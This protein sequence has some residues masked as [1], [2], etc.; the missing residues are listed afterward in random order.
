[1]QA[2]TG[3]SRPEQPVAQ[4]PGSS[5]PSTFM[6][7]KASAAEKGSVSTQAIRMLPATPQRTALTRLL[8]PTPMMHALM[9]C[10]VETGTPKWLAPRI[11]S[12]PAVSAA[13]PWMRRDADDLRAHRLDDALAAR[14]RAERRSRR[15]RDDD[16]QR[17]RVAV[18]QH[19]VRHARGVARATNASSARVM[20]PIDFCASLEPWA[21]AIM[22]AESELQP[23]RRR[24]H[25][26]P[27]HAAARSRAAR[28]SGRT[29]R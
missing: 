10:V 20:M 26:R 17:D 6:E 5:Q 28:S 14:H 19:P 13:K 21:N 9:Q 3:W 12:A 1:M 11:V 7:A 2:A 29:R 22:H 4:W 25:R 16:P 8:A 23:A 18:R 27:A 15:A 24:V